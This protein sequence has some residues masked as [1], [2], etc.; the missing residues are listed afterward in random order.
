MANH[1]AAAYTEYIPCVKRIWPWFWYFS[2][3]LLM[4]DGKYFTH[5]GQSYVQ[6]CNITYTDAFTDC[7]KKGDILRKLYSWA[8]SWELSWLLF[9]T[10]NQTHSEAW[11]MLLHIFILSFKTVVQ[12]EE[13][14]NAHFIITL[15]RHFLWV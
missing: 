2:E 13:G 1:A 10:F 12:R 15:S 14:K 8:K 9:S 4:L 5:D 7:K 6:A 3:A 11:I